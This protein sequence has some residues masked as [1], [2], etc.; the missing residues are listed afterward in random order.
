MFVFYPS[1]SDMKISRIDHIV[2][3]VADIDVTCQF[4][5]QVLGM[6]VVTFGEGRKASRL[7]SKN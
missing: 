1:L 7:V 6:D 5:S 3:T 2:L 4:Y